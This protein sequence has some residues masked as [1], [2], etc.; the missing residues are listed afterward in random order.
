MHDGINGMLSAVKFE[1][2]TEEHLNSIR[3]KLDECIETIRRTAHG[4]MPISLERFGMKIALEDHCRSL[5]N[6]HFHFFGESK[7]IDKKVETMV[8]Y[9][10]YELVNNSCKHSE[11][12]N[13]NVQLI[14]SEKHVSL[15]VHDD[16]CGFDK[17]SVQRGAGLQ[18]IRNRVAALKGKLDIDTSPGKGTETII[19]LKTKG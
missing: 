5:P 1:L 12:K 7:R 2:D 3:D 15:I 18:N 13:I 16:G 9:C 14:Q 11:A 17:E 19:E 4:M 6:V 8:Y 10:A